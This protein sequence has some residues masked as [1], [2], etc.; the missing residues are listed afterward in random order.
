MVHVHQSAFLPIHLPRTHTLQ[1]VGECSSLSVLDVSCNELELFPLELSQLK[2]REFYY[3]NNPLLPHIPV[4]AEQETEV[5][6]LRVSQAWACS[7]A[8][9]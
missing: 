9:V 3:D 1:G 2:L 4:P 8:D 7:D 5:L 6:P